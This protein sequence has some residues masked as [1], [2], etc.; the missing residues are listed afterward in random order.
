MG[1][2]NRDNRSRGNN[3][4]SSGRGGFG[5][6]R[7]QRFDAICDDCGAKFTLPFRPNEGK[8]VYCEECF[9]K[10]NGGAGRRPERRDRREDRRE[11]GFEDRQKFEAICDSCGE[12][13]LLPFKPTAG[14]PVY[15]DNC[16][17]KSKGSS[18]RGS[19]SVDYSKQFESLNEKLEKILNMLS[20]EIKTE[21]VEKKVSAKKVAKKTDKKVVKK[22]TEKKKK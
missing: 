17:S 22:T 14:K 12:K 20:P 1:N 5:G 21:K 4:S 18:N 16:F 3:R 15:C 10:Q 19:S 9:D 2:F 6:S 7:P 13:C 8:P 11:R